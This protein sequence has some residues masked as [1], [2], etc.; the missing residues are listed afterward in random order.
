MQN[1]AALDATFATIVGV[2]AFLSSVIIGAI[3]EVSRCQAIRAEAIC[4]STHAVDAGQI[5]SCPLHACGGFVNVHP[6]LLHV[7]RPGC[8]VCRQ[9]SKEP[10]TALY[11]SLATTI[12]CYWCILSVDA[13]RPKLRRCFCRCRSRRGPGWRS[14]QGPLAV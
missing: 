12:L 14:T 3:C 9:V 5:P 4:L 13:S 7:G 6:L 1:E 2:F 8:M 11:Q 10:W